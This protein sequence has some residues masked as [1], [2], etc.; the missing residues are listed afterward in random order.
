[1]IFQGYTNNIYLNLAPLHLSHANV[2][3]RGVNLSMLH[4]LERFDRFSESPNCKMQI[5]ILIPL[6]VTSV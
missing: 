2:V 4:D 3:S 6:Q 1:M 5:C